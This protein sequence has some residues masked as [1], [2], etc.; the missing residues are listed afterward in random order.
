M[1]SCVFS[2]TDDSSWL[3]QRGSS[4][5]GAGEGEEAGVPTHNR[6]IISVSAGRFMRLFI[7]TMAYSQSQRQ[8]DIRD[9]FQDEPRR[10]LTFVALFMAF[11]IASA[12]FIVCSCSPT[13][14]SCVRIM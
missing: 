1:I 4:E 13:P 10:L 6:L 11:A 3:Q 12:D 8:A 7:D 14:W 5:G 2:S 9:A